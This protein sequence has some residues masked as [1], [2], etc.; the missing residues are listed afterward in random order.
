MIKIISKRYA[1]IGFVLLL[2]IM[3]LFLA[4]CVQNKSG[5]IVGLN[6]KATIVD[7]ISTDEV[8]N[9]TDE[10]YTK[11]GKVH[12]IE[13][14]EFDI[15]ASPSNPMRELY[16]T[17]PESVVDGVLRNYHVIGVKQLSINGVSNVLEFPNSGRLYWENDLNSPNYADNLSNQW[18][19]SKGPYNEY[20]LWESV[21]IYINATSNMNI[22]FEL[23]YYMYNAT[24]RYADASQLHLTL[25]EGEEIKTLNK[26]HGQILFA[27]NLM[28]QKDNCL[29]WAF[30]TESHTVDFS[31]DTT[32]N[33]GYTTFEINLQQDKLKN[34]AKYNMY[35]EFGLISYGE[36]SH[37]FSQYA[38]QNQYYNTQQK[39]WL[40]QQVH[41]WANLPEKFDK[42]QNNVLQACLAS[43]LI[44]LLI[45]FILD[46]ILKNIFQFKPSR[47]TKV[48]NNIPSQV[49]LLFAR[50]LVFCKHKFVVNQA[51]GL[52]G[53]LL[54]LYQKGY[55]E[56]KKLDNNKDWFKNNTI[57]VQHA[58]PDNLP[59]FDTQTGQKINYQNNN[60]LTHSERQYLIL[61]NRHMQN[62]ELLASNFAKSLKY[63]WDSVQVF[64]ADLDNNVQNIGVSQDY[65]VKAKYKTMRT[66]FGWLGIATIFLAL[67]T[68]IIANIVSIQS[69]LQLAKGSFIFLP[70]IMILGGISLILLSK[71]YVKLTEH[72]QEEY[73]KWY[74]FYKYLKKEK[75]NQQQTINLNEIEDWLVYATTFGLSKKHIIKLQ[76]NMLH[77]TQS[78][79]RKTLPHIYSN[80]F[81]QIMFFN[82]SRHIWHRYWSNYFY[83]KVYWNLGGTHGYHGH[84]W[85][86]GG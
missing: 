40:V 60:P 49:D 29:P 19:H 62:N 68:G 69:R 10:W 81:V 58:Q 48:Y 12:V 59:K 28:P 65:F 55:I 31:I 17:M 78:L 11:G 83:R 3:S 35:L 13:Q 61:L 1:A 2:A 39:D 34:W 76:T 20:D 43:G 27:D 70:A 26:V 47:K 86:G 53:V 75:W 21:L 51:Q 42:I 9:E 63:D 5:N 33:A 32:T 82:I 23:E 25:Y 74:G 7:E 6:Y 64:L 85:G 24:M 44:F 73:D 30:G 18:F 37:I 50:E 8:G 84:R 56:F 57:I 67:L 66:I 80:L 45:I 36:D 38:S 15:I 79:D 41:D 4:S 71:K 16:R 52:G 46:L 22:V 54:N 14:L 77:H 72:G